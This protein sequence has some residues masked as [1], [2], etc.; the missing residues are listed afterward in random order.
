VKDRV[1]GVAGLGARGDKDP[2]AGSPPGRAN[3]GQEQPLP[4]TIYPTSRIRRLH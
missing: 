3:E 1:G 2:G 4:A